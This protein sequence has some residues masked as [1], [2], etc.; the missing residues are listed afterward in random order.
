MIEPLRSLVQLKRGETEIAA[1]DEKVGSRSEVIRIWKPVLEVP[2]SLGALLVQR[3]WLRF[4][5]GEACQLLQHDT[6]PRDVD[7]ERAALR[8]LV[9]HILVRVNDHVHRR[10]Q[11]TAH[12]QLLQQALL[13][14]LPGLVLLGEAGIVDHHQQVVIRQVATAA[15]LDQSPRA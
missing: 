5:E 3:E 4:G 11:T 8:Q 10:C 15:I 9:I 14:L 2:S 13:G 6:V 1:L 7:E 12:A